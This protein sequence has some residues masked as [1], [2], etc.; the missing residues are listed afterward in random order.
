MPT[1]ETEVGSL[2]ADVVDVEAVV[3]ARVVRK[4]GV[5]AAHEAHAPAEIR[6]VK[7]AEQAV[8]QVVEVV[9][10]DRAVILL[11]K[12]IPKPQELRRLRIQ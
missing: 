5:E 11:C 4:G 6:A 7:V 12:V 3:R 10:D 1:R 9:L 8:G 2:P